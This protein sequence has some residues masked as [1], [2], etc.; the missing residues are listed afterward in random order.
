MLTIHVNI[1]A[2]SAGR[3]LRDVGILGLIYRL[4]ACQKCAPAGSVKGGVI[5]T[6]PVREGS[7]VYPHRGGRLMST[8]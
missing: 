8:S 7:S 6:R 5:G 4:Q 2:G 1:P 3:P